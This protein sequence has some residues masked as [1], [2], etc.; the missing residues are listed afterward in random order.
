[1]AQIQYLQR[2]QNQLSAT[3]TNKEPLEVVGH[4]ED[5]GAGV[6]WDVEDKISMVAENNYAVTNK[7]K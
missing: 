6:G 4:L 1:M 5:L 2:L 7:H 3:N